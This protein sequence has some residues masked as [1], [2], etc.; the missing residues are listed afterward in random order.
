M[1]SPVSNPNSLSVDSLHKP[2]TR[3]I[4]QL[5]SR[6]AQVEKIEESLAEEP[7]NPPMPAPDSNSTNS[8]FVK[9][10][11]VVYMIGIVT[12][13]ALTLYCCERKGR[14]GMRHRYQ[15]VTLDD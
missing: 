15:V 1:T 4:L 6:S 2:L 7:L 10:F 12:L 8:D 5:Q 14:H 3:F 9:V 11:A 13:L